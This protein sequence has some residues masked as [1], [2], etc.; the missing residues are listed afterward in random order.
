MPALSC[1]S[2][3]DRPSIIVTQAEHE[4]CALLALCRKFNLAGRDAYLVADAVR[5]IDLHLDWTRNYHRGRPKFLRRRAGHLALIANP[6]RQKR[7]HASPVTD[8]RRIRKRL[9]CRDIAGFAAAFLETSA[10][11]Q[12]LLRQALKELDAET[13]LLQP[14]PPLQPADF[15][16]IGRATDL[17]LKRRLARIPVRTE[18]SRA[19][20]QLAAL[21]A[22][23]TGRPAGAVTWNEVEGRLRGPF[24]EFV[25]EV[26]RIYGLPLVTQRSAHLLKKTTGKRP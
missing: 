14:V 16:M 5:R 24:Y 19:V 10:H 1:R 21:F 7:H 6:Y 15:A 2:V 9:L 26:S 4:R 23:L 17:L 20:K 18:R 8:I 25:L 3:V 22:W 12:D 13:K 11:V